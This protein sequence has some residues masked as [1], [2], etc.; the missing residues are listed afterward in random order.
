MKEIKRFLDE[1]IGNYSFYFEDLISGY[2]YA[3][4]ENVAMSVAGCIKLPIAI[5]LLKN[6]ERGII[7]LSEKVEVSGND[8]VYGKGIIHEFGERDYSIGELMIAMLIQGDNTAANKIINILGLSNINE[9][10]KEMGLI[11]TELKS[12][13]LAER[14]EEK[15][16]QN[17]S[18]SEDLSKCWKHLYRGSY[19]NKDNSTMLIEILKRQQM[20]NKIAFYIPNNCKSEIASKPGDLECVENDTVLIS[21]EKG[22]FVLTV[23]SESIPNNI[24]GNVTISRVGKMAWD[25]IKYNWSSRPMEIINV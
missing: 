17:L 1:R 25:I 10:I 6:V 7:N 21:T 14:Y 11:S 23:M 22:D 4:N 9:C 2:V 3:H 8:K 15:N 20:K 16:A 18:S 13:R 19:I 24:Y 12:K 5:A